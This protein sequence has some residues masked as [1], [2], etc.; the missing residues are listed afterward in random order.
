LVG[1]DRI[2]I[3]HRFVASLGGCAAV[4]FG[5]MKVQRRYVNSSATKTPRSSIGR[6]V[7]KRSCA[8]H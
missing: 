3:A 6:L 2:E 5:D 7:G 4:V 8:S 1:G